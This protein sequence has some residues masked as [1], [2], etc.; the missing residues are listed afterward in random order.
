MSIFDKLSM[1]KHADVPFA[2]AD[3]G[4]MLKVVQDDIICEGEL[5]ELSPASGAVHSAQYF[6][7]TKDTLIRCSV[8]LRAWLRISQRRKK[9]R[10]QFLDCIIHG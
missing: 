6:I 8:W 2:W 7:A 5:K 3:P 4:A 10:E 9:S 1:T